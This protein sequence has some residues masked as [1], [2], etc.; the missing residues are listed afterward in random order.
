VSVAGHFVGGRWRPLVGGWTGISLVHSLIPDLTD[1]EADWILWE[2]TPFPMVT[3]ADRLL[4]YLV[5][6]QGEIVAR[7]THLGA[8]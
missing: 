8:L 2:R 1:G 7:S 4:P 3:D 5:A 6:E